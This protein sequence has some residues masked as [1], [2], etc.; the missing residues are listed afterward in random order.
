MR[1]TLSFKWIQY[2][3]FLSSEVGSHEI[4]QNSAGTINSPQFCILH[5][6]LFFWDLKILDIKHVN[7]HI[8]HF[9]PLLRKKAPYKEVQMLNQ[10]SFQPYCITNVYFIDRNLWKSM[11][12]W[13]FS[14]IVFYI[15]ITLIKAIPNITIFLI[16]TL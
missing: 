8:S 6:P 5:S 4:N 9:L 12:L 15:S 3:P 13:Y 16:K 1:S 7:L 2:P 10:R 14:M 11:T